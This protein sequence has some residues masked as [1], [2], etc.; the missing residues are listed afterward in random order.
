[1]AVPL[2]TVEPNRFTSATLRRVNQ[3]DLSNRLVMMLYSI[4]VGVAV[5]TSLKALPLI[6]TDQ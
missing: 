5:P 6:D 1:M 2:G 4:W 3:I